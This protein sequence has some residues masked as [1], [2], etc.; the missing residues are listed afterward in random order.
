MAQLDCSS[1]GFNGEDPSWMCAFCGISWW[2]M[3]SK[4]L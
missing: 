1:V 4:I 2:D 3:F